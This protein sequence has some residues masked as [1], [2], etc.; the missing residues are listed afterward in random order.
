MNILIT[1]GL[2]FVGSVI[3][4]H[5]LHKGFKVSVI[6]KL[7]FGNS[8]LKYFKK[9]FNLKID[10]LDYAKVEKYFKN[11][12][13]DIV[14]HLAAIVGD[15]ASKVNLDLTKK[16]NLDASIRLFNISKKYKVNKFIFFST[17]S[18]YGLSKNS[19]LLK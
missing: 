5:L 1:G 7:L 17:C 4:E 18:N 10:I 9:I 6:D 3:T 13:F 19:K 16:T 2:G 14:F 12:N 15:P 8:H 11:N